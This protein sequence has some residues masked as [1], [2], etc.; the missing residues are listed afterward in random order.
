M[1]NNELLNRVKSGDEEAIA[2]ALKHKGAIY[3]IN[4]LINIVRHSIVDSPKIIELT[5]TLLQD[6]I[7]LDGYEVSDFAY[8]T[9]DL[10]GIES[11][12]GDNQRVK[13]LIDSRFEF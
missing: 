2:I 9:L 11:Y 6:S 10:I 13:A 3:R 12:S 5:Y 8:A 7:M 1:E 4:A